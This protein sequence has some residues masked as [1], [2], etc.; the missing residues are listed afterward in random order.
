[1]NVVPLEWVLHL[2]NNY[3]QPLF[4][5]VSKTHFHYLELH[6]IMGD[7]VFMGVSVLI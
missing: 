5:T 2:K 3:Y 4:K 1:M 7:K 6:I